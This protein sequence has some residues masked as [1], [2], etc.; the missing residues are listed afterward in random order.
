MFLNKNIVRCILEDNKKSW[1]VLQ[2]KPNSYKIAERNLHRQQFE[3]FLP[4]QEIKKIERYRDKTFH[5]PLFPGYMFIAC[6][7]GLSKLHKINNTYGV[8]KIVS[9]NN[10]PR[11]VSGGFIRELKQH[12]NQKGIFH[13]KNDLK[14]GDRVKIS[15]GPF[16]NLLATIEKLDAENRVWLLMDLINVSSKISI[17]SQNETYD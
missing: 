17:N 11:A 5:K 4:F 15:N 9:F 14:I 10:Q 7:C 13:S 1:F 6:D 8:N 16:S 2:Y 12:C 3:T